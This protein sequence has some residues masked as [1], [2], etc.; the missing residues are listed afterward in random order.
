MARDEEYK[1][2]SP[3]LLCRLLEHAYHLSAPYV[4]VGDSFDEGW[5]IVKLQWLPYM[6]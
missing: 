3:F 1:E 2:G 5:W 4:V 6:V